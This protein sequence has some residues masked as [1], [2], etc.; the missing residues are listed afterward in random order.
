MAGTSDGNWAWLR[1][2][3]MVAPWDDDK[4]YKQQSPYS[5]I[6]NVV[7][8]VL[9]EVQEGDLRCPF[10]QG[11]MYFAALKYLNKAPVKFVTYPNEFHGMSR[12]GK[13]WNK[14]HRLHQIISWLNQYGK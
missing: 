10:E 13:P 7:T 3:D 8:P 14:V 5:Y 4:A 1:R 9:I 6:S 11:Q 12:N 2:F